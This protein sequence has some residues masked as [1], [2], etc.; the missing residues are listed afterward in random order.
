MAAKRM[1]A[2][3]K[4]VK[5]AIAAPRLMARS[6]HQALAAAFVSRQ[7]SLSIGSLRARQGEMRYDTRGARRKSI[8]SCQAAPSFM[9]HSS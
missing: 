6:S 7:N 2:K 8:T 4:A 9:K 5:K 1:G 3:E